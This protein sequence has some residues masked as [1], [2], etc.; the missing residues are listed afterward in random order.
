MSRLV[1]LFD[2]TNPY[3]VVGA[4]QSAVDAVLNRDVLNRLADGPGCEHEYQFVHP[5]KND[6]AVGSARILFNATP[7]IASLFIDAYARGTGVILIRRSSW[8]RESRVV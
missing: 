3:A 7:G 4:F 6:P 5:N 1:L 8:Y 2:A